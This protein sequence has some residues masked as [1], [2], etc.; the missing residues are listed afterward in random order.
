M[1]GLYEIAPLLI[2]Q[3]IV[4][5]F[6]LYIGD[7]KFVYFLS[8]KILT[9]RNQP[10][11]IDYIERNVF[12][13]CCSFFFEINLGNCFLCLRNLYWPSDKTWKTHDHLHLEFSCEGQIF[14]KP[15]SYQH[16]AIYSSK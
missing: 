10:Q 12:F 1:T 7:S 3:M 8:L 15:F 5:R 6:C 16:F 2:L 4:F 14:G 13:I 11:Q 9:N